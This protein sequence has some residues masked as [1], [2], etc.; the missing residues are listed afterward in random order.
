MS[1]FAELC[2]SARISITS[3]GIVCDDDPNAAM[4]RFSANLMFN[5][6]R[7]EEFLK[8]MRE[9]MTDDIF[10]SKVCFLLSV[11]ASLYF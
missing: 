9:L 10:L 4:R 1:I 3:M 11:S 7:I 2:S 6:N 8:D 5:N